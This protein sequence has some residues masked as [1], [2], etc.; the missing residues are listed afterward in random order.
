M[1]FAL[2]GIAMFGG[3]AL[4]AFLCDLA[5]E[6]LRRPDVRDHWQNLDR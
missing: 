4:A 3:L 2:L 5:E 1:T 6:W